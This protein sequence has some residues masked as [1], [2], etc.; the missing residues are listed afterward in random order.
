MSPP[1]HLIPRGDGN[2]DAPDAN[3]N[4]GNSIGII[5]NIAT[6]DNNNE[7]HPVVEDTQDGEVLSLSTATSA[8]SIASALSDGAPRPRSASL[9]IMASSTTPGGAGGAGSRPN[10]TPRQRSTP[11]SRPRSNPRTRTPMRNPS[12]LLITGSRVVEDDSAAAPAVL[13]ESVVESNDASAAIIDNESA[14]MNVFN[15]SRRH[16][17]RAGS[18]PEEHEVVAVD[19]IDRSTDGTTEQSN[20]NDTT[21]ASATSAPAPRAAGHWLAHA[22]TSNAATSRNQRSTNPTRSRGPRVGL[23]DK[24]RPSHRKLRRWNN[25]RFVGT[26]SENTHIMLEASEGGGAE[27][28][29]REFY[30]P[31][32]PCEYRS[33]FAKLSC[34]DSKVGKIVK[35]RFLKGEVAH[36]KKGGE[37][38]DG[39]WMERS[40]LAKFHKLGVS[41]PEPSAFV[42]NCKDDEALALSK[43]SN[44]ALEQDAMGKKLF[45]SINNRIQSVVS[46][47]CSLG[48]ES[49]ISFA[50]QVVM[51]FESYLISL[52]LSG[53]KHDVTP[54]MGY[55]PRQ[56][57]HVYEIFDKIFCNPPKVVIRN[58]HHR[59]HIKSAISPSLQSYAVL[60]PT[61]HFY[62]PAD[63]NNGQQQSAEGVRSSAF[64]RILL[65]AVCQFHGLESSSTVIAP[66]KNKQTGKQKRRGSQQAQERG[67]MKV[68]TV[69]G[70]V[71]LAPVLKLLD[72]NAVEE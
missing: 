17:S 48:D 37:E 69:Q 70:G 8:T 49:N 19:S 56:P 57:Q 32:Y 38:E 28:Y 35:E 10:S 59:H 55:P 11:R 36:H 15:T 53:S 61:V 51:A 7:T 24:Q 40:V 46:R 58:K 71:L 60:V 29:F 34:D 52:A 42:P 25:D 3:A 12:P 31:N 50:S 39:L 62:F 27:Q 14:V 2:A 30:M 63:D 65:Y 22:A 16:R 67:G 5:E 47:S 20:Q 43:S 4:N 33:E 18:I 45:Q 9:S 44:I 21:T 41:L 72:H 6:L 26:S 1:I 68:V 64:Y 66:K 23:S 13:N 54:S